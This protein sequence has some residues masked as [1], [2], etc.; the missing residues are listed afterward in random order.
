MIIYFENYTISLFENYFVTS[1]LNRFSNL[2][3]KLKATL[4]AVPTAYDMHLNICFYIKKL[5]F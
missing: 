4:R 1:F 5:S 2:F 3:S